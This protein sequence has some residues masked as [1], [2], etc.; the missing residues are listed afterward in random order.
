MPLFISEEEFR[1]CSGDAVLVAEKADAYIQG[2]YRQIETVKAEA[3]AASITREQTCSF[4]EQKYVSLSAEY[5][6]LQSQHS[7]LNSSLEGRTSELAQLQSEKQQLLL[8]SIEKDGEIE[9][10]TREASELH[11]SKRQLMEMLEQKDLEVGEKNT[12]IKSYL[13]KIVNL[14]ENAASKEARLG[15]LESEMGRLHAKCAR[16]LQE[17]ELLERHNTWLNEEL[18]AKVDSLIQLR[19]T[20]G[21]LEADM[22]S[23]LAD[24]ERKFEESSR[25]LKLHK[26]RLR[27]LEEKL[28]STEG[29]LLSTKDAAAAAE[30][31][32]SAEISTVTKLVDLYK[33]S[34]DEWSK[35][36]GELEG[37]IKALETHLNQVEND[38]KYRLE[39]EVSARKEVAKESADLREKLQTTEAEVEKL[40]K[41][42]ELRL[43]PLSSFTTD[44]WVNSVETGE[45]VVDDRAIVPRIPAGVSGTAL[46]ASLLRDGWTLAKMYAKYQE[47]VDALRHE[48]LGR[49]QTQAILERVLYEIEEKAGVIMDERE[50]HERIV[51][52]YSALDQ[53]LQHSLS[54]RST[55]ETTIQELKAGLKRQERDY[56]AAQQEL[57]DL[58]KQV[59]VLL[60]E[61][62]DVQLR[63]GSVARHNDDELISTPA[64]LLNAES[65]AE[66]IISE[67]LL[68]F[69]DI[70][71]LVEQNVQ[72]RSLVRNLSEHIEEKEAELK[73]KYEKELQMQTDEAASKVNSVLLRA[74]EQARMIES[75]HTSVAMYKKLYEEE[76]KL[77]SS[78]PRVQEAV[79]EQ[80]SREVVLFH[81]SSHDMS[82]KVQEQAL[83]RVKNLEEDLAK[84]RN[85]IISLRAERDKLAL[86]AQFAQEKLARFMKEFE[87]Q[88]EEHNGVL[89]RNVEFSQFIV[90]YQ[91]Q[92]RESSE[93][94][95]AA[96]E[97]S[98]KLTMEV[99]I[100]KHE[101]EILQNAEKRA[102]DEVRSLSE[103]VHRLQATL[104]TIQSTEEVREEARG[105]ER[106]K[107]EEYLNKIEREWAEVKRELQE[108][109]DNVRNLTLE[110]ESTLKNALRQ[111]EDLSKE[112]ANALQ[113]VAAAESRAAIAEARCSDLEK[114]MESARAKDSDGGPSSSTSEKILANF[115]EEIE[116]LREELQASKDHMQQYKSI[117]EVSEEALKQM[118]SA[119][120]TFRNEADE[121][122]RSL[123]TELLSLRERVNELE[124]ECI[125]KTEEAISATSGK[126]EA[127]AGALSEIAGLKDDF[128]VKMSQ[129]VIM[130]SQILALKEDLEK[131]HQRWRAA[132]DNYERQVILQSETIQE[133]TKTSQALASAQEETSELRKVVDVLKTENSELKSTWE[134]EKLAIEVYRNEADKKYSEVNELNKILHSRLEALH[135]KLAEKERGL[136]S[137][138]GS[139][140]LSD[141]DGLQNVMNYLRRSKEIAETEIS[142]L[143]QEK[144]RLQSQLESAMKSAEAAQASLHSERSKSRASLFN[145]EEF[146]SI[147]LQVRELNLLRESNVQLREEN[148]HNF[149]ECQKLREALQNL[150]I[151]N[152]NLEKLLRVRD[153]DLEASRKEIEAF[154]MEKVNLEKRIDELVEKCKNVDVDDYNR[155]KESF[156]Q[157]Q[158]SLRE[159]DA[160]LEEIKKTLS[161]KQ[162]AISILERDLAKSRTE[163]NERENRMNEILQSEASLK[164]DVEKVRRINVQSRRKSEN[165]S[166][167]KEELTK[168]IQSLS[169]QLDEAKQ[170]KRNVVDPAAEQVFKEKEK[171]K[172]AR[173][174]ILEKTLERLRDELKKEKEKTKN[175]RK[176]IVEHREFVAQQH[177][178]VSDELKK[179]KQAL[180]ALQDDVE[181]LGGSSQSESIAN[182]LLEDFASA[183]FQAV[184]NFEQVAQPARGDLDPATSSD[185]P[186]SLDN[187]SSAGVSVGQT[188]AVPAANVSSTKTNEEK[189]RRFALVARANIKTGRRL[190]RPSITKPKE[191]EAADVDMS[192]AES[193]NIPENQGNPGVP[194]PALT[195][196]RSSSPFSTDT[197]E[198]TLAPEEPSPDAPA[199]PLKKPKPSEG[200]QEGSEEQSSPLPE[201][202]PTEEPSDDVEKNNLQQ[203]SV[204]DETVDAEKDESET[205]VE[206]PTL[207][208]QIQIEPPSEIPDDKLDKPSEAVLS[209]DQLRDETEQDIQR[210]VAESGGDRE[211]GEMDADDNDGDSN[212]SNE[213]AGPG[214]SQP[215][216]SVEPENSPSNEPTL[217][218]GEIEPSQTPPEEEKNGSETT[219]NPDPIAEMDRI[220]GSEKAAATEEAS[221]STPVDVGGSEQGGP[222]ADTG[223]KPVSPVN[224]STTTTIN[225]QERARERAQRRYASMAAPPPGRGRG[226]VIRGRGARGGRTPRG[227]AP[228]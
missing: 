192:E 128:A 176:T 131:E 214:E 77:H 71:G 67:R 22:S 224:S 19:K 44:S 227:Q 83:E 125:L 46:A 93:S 64:F 55:L 36:A 94:V 174:Q 57:I 75:L 7:E 115:R 20:N 9:R 194:T 187:T 86:E 120:E 219:D 122:K 145:E 51:E 23:K 163:L 130:E 91:R 206:E 220:H 92:L 31:R 70:N 87:H 148:R 202:V 15:D 166:K 150:K 151:E 216:Q 175:D 18:T 211:E 62:R 35:K 17:K 204:K 217:E 16:L 144:H 159:K 173:I 127:F 27:E 186:K 119:H 212:V 88:R 156:Q 28:V 205:E 160:Q 184:E 111:V 59:S 8:Q 170:A 215:D 117:A 210:I 149:E 4:I 61:C 203:D 180:K 104:D 32:F 78:Y 48:Q 103:R 121:V 45:M 100:L 208:E 123:E 137:G 198:E 185:A 136:A 167:E 37:V 49:K 106:R 147:Q 76:H 114:I 129:V 21:E 90:D 98:R 226:R 30:E 207:D 50:E 108:E 81:G 60:K 195:R 213:M 74:E 14:T 181:K 134:A 158:A 42:N 177:T 47:A 99:S 68:T 193:Q 112:L 79:P 33:E 54:E 53:K 201:V 171:E 116:K 157:M 146:K 154:K 139:Q 82:T 29:E 228:G 56:A 172:D 34:S 182:N 225:L 52:A 153:A 73:Y 97:L 135:I 162:D 169:K 209:D 218:A 65:I 5:S 3:D 85:D 143:K 24:V 25:S 101:K 58:Q 161:V 126:E 199:H 223:G 109:R 38:Y 96:N 113:S 13:D 141:D 107:Q 164:S 40:R 178:K 155:L 118:E 189:E 39:N 190:V 110:R 179:H 188:L 12:T 102:S 191:P 152:E 133:L 222:A 200:P 124:S 95:N 132:Q 196:K 197:Q 63:C 66:N 168:E 142:L 43:L 80:G 10:L 26:D 2:L 89:S 183:Y 84:S 69:K 11:K 1:R 221:T 41:E 138:G 72:L 6:S 105:I 165:L 140:T